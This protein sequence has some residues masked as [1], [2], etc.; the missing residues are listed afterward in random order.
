[1]HIAP[2]ESAPVAGSQTLSRGLKAIEI[3]ADA[4]QPLTLAELTDLL[5]VH[6]SNAYRVVRTLEDHRFVLRDQAG[7]IRL[8]PRLAALARGVAPALNSAAIGPVTQ[9]ANA[10]GIT[11]FIT[12]LD[13][14]EVITVL[15]AEPSNVAANVARKPGVRHHITSGAPGH[16]IEASLTARERMDLLG[17]AEFGKAAEHARAHGYAVSRN[18]VIQGVSAIAVPL[19]ISGEPPAALALVHFSLPEDL[20]PLS[21]QLH[22]TA[23][24]IAQNYH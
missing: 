13:A 20:G 21:E 24:L 17:S 7:L 6:R 19:R 4:E 16:A 23:N 10:L 5:G 11:A 3:L 2:K 9:L 8:G 12:V 22:E 18:E 14:D 15:A 1:M